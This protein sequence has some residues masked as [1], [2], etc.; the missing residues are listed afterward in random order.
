ML[1]PQEFIFC[2]YQN[3]DIV[4]FLAYFPYFEKIK[5]AYEIAML[6]VCLCIP[7]INF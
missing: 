5:Q 6:S 7:H 3:L 1:I 2:L 4:Y